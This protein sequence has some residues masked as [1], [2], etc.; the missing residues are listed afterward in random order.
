[1]TN[2]ITQRNISSR[3]CCWWLHWLVSCMM[4]FYLHR[5]QVKKRWIKKQIFQTSRW[6]PAGVFLDSLGHNKSLRFN[7][8]RSR[9]GNPKAMWRADNMQTGLRCSEVYRYCPMAASILSLQRDTEP[10]ESER[11]SRLTF[12]H[13]PVNQDYSSYLMMQKQSNMTFEVRILYCGTATPS[14]PRPQ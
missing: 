12:P 6:K 2:A 9:N 1:M 4:S 5:S 3:V 8:H 10:R 11:E 14:N 7:L 13:F